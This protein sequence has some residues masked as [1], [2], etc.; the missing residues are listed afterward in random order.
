MTETTSTDF[1]LGDIFETIFGSAFGGGRRVRAQ[2]LTAPW[3][4]PA[5]TQRWVKM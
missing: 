5:M 1:N 2:P 3:V 4:T